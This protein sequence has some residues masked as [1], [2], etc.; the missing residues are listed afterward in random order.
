[1]GVG[2]TVGVTMGVGVKVGVKVGVGVGVG[3]SGSGSFKVCT[4]RWAGPGFSC[5][6]CLYGNARKA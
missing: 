1:M 4:E 5:P 2:V 6:V 3:V